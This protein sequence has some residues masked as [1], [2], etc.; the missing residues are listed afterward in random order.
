MSDAPFDLN[1]PTRTRVKRDDA[2]DRA[3]LMGTGDGEGGDDD[4]HE[5]D[6][7]DNQELHSKLM[8]HYQ[9]ELDRQY[10]NR[11]QMAIDE[12]YYDSIQWSEEDAQQVRDRNQV[13]IVYNV[14]SQS[15]NWIIGSEKRGRTDFRILP[16]EKNDAK[17]AERK[18]QLLKY[19]SDVNRTVFH[20]SRAFE[21]AT[22]VGIGWL[23]DGAQDDDDDEEIIYSR[24]ESWRNVLWDS[25]S[26]EMDLSDAR[27]MYR[28]KWIDADVAIAMFP[29]RAGLIKRSAIAADRLQY[30]AYHGD[31][32]MD[33]QENEI[34][35]GLS[36]ESRLHMAE[37]MRVR[38]IECWFRKPATMSVLNG[39]SFHGQPYDP[40]NEVMAEEVKTGQAVV[41]S[42]LKMRMHCAVMTPEGLCYIAQSPYRHNR[43][44]FTPIWGYRR[45]RDNLPYGV[46]RSMRDIQDD[47]NKRAS[48]AQ[49]ILATNKV[50]AEN[51]VVDDWQEL[52][53][54]VSRPDG[55]VRVKPGRMGAIE[56]NSDRGMDVSHLELMSREISMIQQ[57]SG[58]TDELLGRTT[59]AQSGVAVERRQTQGMMSTSKLFDNLRFA[60]QLQGE[61]QLSL[62][63]QYFTEEK[64]FRITN[65]RGTPEYVAINDGQEGNDIVGRK[66]DFVISED[67]Y[68]AT[69]RQA[70]NDQL[71]ELLTKMPPQV[72]MVMLDLVVEGMDV[73]NREAL[74]N[75]IRAINGQRDPD[76]DELTPEEQ[77][78]MQAQAEQ[79]EMQ[80][81]MFMAEV[82]GKVAEAVKKEVEAQKAS[83]EINETNMDVQKLAVEAAEKVLQNPSIA[84]L[85]DLLL[86]ESGYQSETDKARARQQMAVQQAQQAL[87]QQ[88]QQ[89]QQPGQPQGQGL[90]APDGAAPNQPM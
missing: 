30:D 21:D 18:T 34:D 1:D 13:P 49:Y 44:P 47:I 24:Y 58:V 54:E 46:I 23:E 41:N 86:K 66:A 84:P 2:W 11:I 78:R 60:M 65:S 15:I 6:S 69:M 50:V 28:S 27:Y 89:Q 36:S 26:T 64:R 75:R 22:K 55:V 76:A 9:N 80:K 56:L 12:D 87:Q 82:R 25:S 59:N 40:D 83:A 57:V 14:L 63:E 5:L 37:R 4:G 52:M 70:Q 3:D 7:A 42:R 33:S 72:A 45:G 8:G 79:A 62:M 20:R 10:D 35:M 53:E 77:Q 16:R 32:A 88:A 81:Q 29:E 51:D 74:V 90:P 61:K 73:S 31:E 48:K 85:A 17:P 68:R 67:E 38:M 43:F 71:I 39:G 19:L